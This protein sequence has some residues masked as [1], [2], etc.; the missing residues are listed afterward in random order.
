MSTV[1]QQVEAVSYGSLSVNCK[2]V[3]MRVVTWAITKVGLAMQER[4]TKTTQELHRESTHDFLQL[5]NSCDIILMCTEFLR[6]D[7]PSAS[8]VTVIKAT[9]KKDYSTGN[10]KVRTY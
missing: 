1:Q 5:V 7:S 6:T 2:R 3:F 10:D 8:E 4:R 9:I